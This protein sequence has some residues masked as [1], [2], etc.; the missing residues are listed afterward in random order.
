MALFKLLRGQ[1]SDLVNQPLHDGYVW[2]TKD[3]HNMW[4]DYYDETNTLVRKRINSEYADKLRYV[5]DGATIELDP[6]EIVM[7]TELAS[8]IELKADKTYV[9]GLNTAT[10]T[11]VDALE[12]WHSNFVEVSEEDINAL[13]V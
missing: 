3:L 12:V 13:F 2:V 4:F 1:E 8:A 5:K 11:R 7:K 9:D 6:S 10:N